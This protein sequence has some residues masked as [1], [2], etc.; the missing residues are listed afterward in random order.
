MEN[1][2]LGALF[3]FLHHIAAFALVGAVTA[4]FLLMRDSIDMKSAR[5]LLAAD[6]V[7][8]MSAGVVLVAGV[9]RVVYFEKGVDY[10]LHS[11]T[12]I[13][14]LSLFAAVGLLSVIPTRE[15]L[16]WRHALRQGQPPVLPAGKARLIRRVIRWEL[17]GIVAIILCAAL[18]AR[19]IG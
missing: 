1:T 18:M 15:L 6:L 19:G 13:A 12:F 5:R 14:K 9:L 8:G 11:G 7:L 10:Y 4:E 17:I 16:S 2:M 3:A